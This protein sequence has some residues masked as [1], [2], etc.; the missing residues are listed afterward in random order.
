MSKVLDG[1]HSDE[2]ADYREGND[3]KELY[4]LDDSDL[5]GFKVKFNRSLNSC[6]IKNKRKVNTLY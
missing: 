4:S 1:R 3:P 6:Q 2:Y 5:N